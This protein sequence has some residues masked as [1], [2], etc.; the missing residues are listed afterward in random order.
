MKLR[1]R[2]NSIRLRL[3]QSEVNQLRETGNLSETIT[4]GIKPT[5]QFIYALRISEDIQ[6][7][8]AQMLNNHIEIFLPVQ[9]TEFWMNNDDEVGIYANQSVSS[10]INLEIIIEKDFACPTRPA[11]LDNRDAF[12]N[13]EVEC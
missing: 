8:Q 7:V 2:E 12:P 9:K 11:D 3:L 13:S 10:D 5:K 4:L 6:D 1:L